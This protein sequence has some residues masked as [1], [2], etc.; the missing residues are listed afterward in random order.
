MIYNKNRYKVHGL[1][2]AL[3][4]SKHQQITTNLLTLIAPNRFE[5]E[6][7]IMFRNTLTR[8]PGAFG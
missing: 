1:D 5:P 2:S 6:T 7:Y 8:V 3:L 4:T